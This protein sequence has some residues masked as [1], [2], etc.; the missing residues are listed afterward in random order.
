[1]IPVE[2]LTTFDTY[3]FLLKNWSATHYFSLATIH[4]INGDSTVLGMW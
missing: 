1:M 2:C 3:N 4:F